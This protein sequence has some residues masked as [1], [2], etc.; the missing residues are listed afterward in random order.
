VCD[1]PPLP[2]AL[3]SLVKHGHVDAPRQSI[4][5]EIC[6]NHG[7][8]RGHAWPLAQIPV[9]ANLLPLSPSTWDPLPSHPTLKKT[10]ART[11]LL[12][13]PR[14][15]T[16]T[17]QR[18]SRPRCLAHGPQKPGAPEPQTTNPACLR[19]KLD[20]GKSRTICVQARLTHG[21]TLEC[22]EKKAL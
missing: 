2:R 16:W 18:R 1:P 22:L 15:T 7:R 12:G 9:T 4:E 6:S 8:I 20:E 11:H 10:R 14:W 13:R 19:G 5:Q 3:L 17:W 21:L